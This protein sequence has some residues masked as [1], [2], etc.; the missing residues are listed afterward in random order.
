MM[1]LVAGLAV[2][3]SPLSHL[4]V[5]ID[6]QIPQSECHS[7]LNNLDSLISET[8]AELRNISINMSI[9]R[10]IVVLPAAW[11]N[12]TCV[13]GL[14]RASLASIPQEADILVKDSLDTDIRTLQYGGCGVR[15]RRVI[16][17][18]S[19]LLIPRLQNNE[20]RASSTDL[21]H[22]L[23][24]HEFGYFDTRTGRGDGPLFPELYKVGEEAELEN[25]NRDPL[26]DADYKKE[27]PTKQNLMCQEQS[28]MSVITSSLQKRISEEERPGMVPD[29]RGPRYEY[30]IRH[31]ERHLLV[32]DRSQ[33]SKQVWKHLHNAL[34][35]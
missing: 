13:L 11:H 9:R 32:L 14:P 23:L 22:S 15:S 27:A 8:S 21:L 28:P 18:R 5:R 19:R 2:S 1:S 31:S 34:H 30:V 7:T 33:E 29:G 10:V 24:K 20:T 16:L 12:A 26:S 25:C 3:T 17:P 35:R 6:D 4:T